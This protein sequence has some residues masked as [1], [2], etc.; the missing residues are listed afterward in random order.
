M[1]TAI[2]VA[3]AKAEFAS[4]VARA[5]AGED[6]IVTRNGKPVVRLMGLQS[7]PV[8]YGDL[9]GLR[10]S[11]DLTLPDEILAGFLPGEAQA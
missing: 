1:S 3:Q 7:R 6:I 9:A 5:E 10:F 2:S 11:E 4:L 8:A